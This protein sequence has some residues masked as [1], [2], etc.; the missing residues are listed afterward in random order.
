MTS[1]ATI[2][3]CS[4]LVPQ[5]VRLVRFRDPSGVSTSAAA[6]GVIQT[7]SWVVYGL[8]T[9]AWAVVVPSSLA[10]PQYVAVV[11]L[12]A[13]TAAARWRAVA[14]VS[15]AASIVFAVTVASAWWGPGPWTGLGVTVTAA[16]AWQ[17]LPAVASAFG[18]DGT[19]GLSVSTW[20]LIGT[21]GLVWTAYG[22][23]THAWAVSA[24]GLVL[25]TATAAVLSAI[26]RDRRR[27]RLGSDPVQGTARC[28]RT[29]GRPPG[30][31]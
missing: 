28:G 31:D 9:G 24:Y 22:A 30:D 1:V 17:Y 21:N 13:T 18:T 26:T 3:G 25:I 23:I 12:T 8:G 6:L 29:D 11:L 19:L 16:V 10:L 2:V 20:L 27:R 7:A 4:F 14:L 15:F 5:I